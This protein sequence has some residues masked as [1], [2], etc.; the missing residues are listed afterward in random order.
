MVNTKFKDE[1]DALPQPAPYHVD[2][3][4][5]VLYRSKRQV[6]AEVAAALERGPVFGKLTT[7]ARLGH[8]PNQPNR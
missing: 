4:G 5:A 6:A 1:V 2:A 3:D 7:A 8:R